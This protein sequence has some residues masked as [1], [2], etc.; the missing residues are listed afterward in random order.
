MAIY[1]KRKTKLVTEALKAAPI[2]P[3]RPSALPPSI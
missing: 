2:L 1:Y 3:P